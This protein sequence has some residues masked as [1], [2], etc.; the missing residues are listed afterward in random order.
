MLVF[1]TSTGHRLR[2]VHLLLMLSRYISGVYQLGDLTALSYFKGFLDGSNQRQSVSRILSISGHGIGDPEIWLSHAFP[3]A[4]IDA[5]SF[6][7]VDT[8]LLQFLRGAGPAGVAQVF[9]QF[10]TATEQLSGLRDLMDDPGLVPYWQ[11]QA[12]EWGDGRRRVSVFS[13]SPLRLPEGR[14]YDVIYVSNSARYLQ[15]AALDALRRH[16][17]PGGRMAVLAA[18]NAADPADQFFKSPYVRQGCDLLD[19]LLEQHGYSAVCQAHQVT[20]TDDPSTRRELIRFT[21][22]AAPK[23]VLVGELL[24]YSMHEHITDRVRLQ[25]LSD[26]L[27]DVPPAEVI[28]RETLELS[29]IEGAP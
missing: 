23:S 5:L 25:V 14:A 8:Q 4:A 11:L 3:D 28:A 12:A 26:V 16:L 22:P 9:A 13:T 1:Q 18:S 10:R 6:R 24:L 2:P 17:A 21:I 27:R 20:D 7:L 29:L 19:R 15:P